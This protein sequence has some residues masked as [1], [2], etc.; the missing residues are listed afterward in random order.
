M[1]MKKYLIVTISVFCAVSYAC[2]Q[3]P[4]AGPLRTSSMD[5]V[6]RSVSLNN[7]E[8]QALTQSAEA[9]MLQLKTEN[10][11][12]DPTI[13]YSSFYSPHLT[14][15]SGSELVV[16]QGFDFPTLYAARHKRNELSRT[17]LD[18]SLTA[19][20]RRILLEAKMLCYDIIM[21]RQ[22]GALL[23]TQE[24]IAGRLLELF[25]E[26]F[27]VG[28]A[29]ALELNKIKMELMD[30]AATVAGN[31]ASLSASVNSLSAMN[32]DAGLIFE[33]DSYPVAEDVPD[34]QAAVDEYL[35]GNAAVMAAENAADAARKQISID[36]QGWIPKLE[37]GYRRN[38]AI[39]EAENGFIVGVS[40]PI[41]SNHRKVGVAKANAVSAGSMLNSVRNTAKAEAVSI[42]EDIMKTKTELDAYDEPLM[43]ETLDLLGE[44][45]E[46]G[47][48]SVID[49][50]VE[51]AAIYGNLETCITL[52]NR[53]HKLL[54]QLYMNRL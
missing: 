43:R 6:L 14:G 3:E 2:A 41:F 47:Q 12:E 27:G 5:E 33:A 21:Y 26:R 1:K 52:R 8:L 45:V 30:V 11:L 29:T 53:Y 31:A 7:P 34:M 15:Q 20:R 28:D 25:D 40:I 50:F 35:S 37:I 48:I 22:L 54:A 13:E 9:S 42:A 10:M 51:A 39:R 16:S 19:E 4:A 46:N 17:S 23:D 36:R 38:T 24:E 32:G 44:A 49:Y 18:N